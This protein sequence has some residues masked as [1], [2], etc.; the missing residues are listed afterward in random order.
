MPDRLRAAFSPT[1]LGGYRS[2]ADQTNNVIFITLLRVVCKICTQERRPE[3][4]PGGIGLFLIFWF[5]LIK[6]KER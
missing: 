1:L 6:Q 4:T 5:F 2:G 3:Q